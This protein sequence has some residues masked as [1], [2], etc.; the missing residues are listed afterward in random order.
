M[1]AL[2][3]RVLLPEGRCQCGCGRITPV[4]SRTNLRKGQV[5]GQ[6]QEVCTR[7]RRRRR[8]KFRIIICEHS[9]CWLWAGSINN[10]GYGRIQVHGK[11][12]SAQRALYQALTGPIPKDKC[13]D[14]GCRNRRC[15]NPAHVE[16][17]T[18]SKNNKRIHLT[19]DEHRAVIKMRIDPAHIR[20]V[21]DQ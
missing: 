9:G 10:D 8:P 6:H 14:H 1:S 15:V 13:V 5:A 20:L 3:L 19:A 4:P 16:A 2:V 18:Y 21:V 17:C 11:H 12:T 7:H